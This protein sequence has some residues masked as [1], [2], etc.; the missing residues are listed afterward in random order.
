MYSLGATRFRPSNSESDPR[1]STNSSRASSTLWST[2]Q[3]SFDS[4]SGSG[5]H[6]APDALDGADY[7]WV[8]YDP[9]LPRGYRQLPS[10][11]ES[12]EVYDFELSAS[13]MSSHETPED[14]CTELG[15][16]SPGESPLDIRLSMGNPQAY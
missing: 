14:T 9:T 11:G 4:F 13:S 16:E 1:T 15:S 7:Q 6:G 2:S 10:I 12:D 8:I 5:E 3:D